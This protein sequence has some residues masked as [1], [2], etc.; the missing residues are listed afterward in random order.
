MNGKNKISVVIN[1]YNAEQHLDRVLTAVK[2]FDELLICDM[3]STDH[4]LEIAQRHG[5][6][7]VTFERK[8]YNIVE[9]AREYAIHEASCEWVLV[10]DADEVVTPA[11][12]D[13]LYS[14]IQQ[15][16]CPD[17][18][19]IPRKNYFMGRFLHSAYPDY[20]LRFFRR[21]LTHWPAVI[22]C[23][24]EVAGRTERISAKQ[25]ALA[26]EHLAND[27]V[28]DILQ[29]NNIYSDNEVPRRQHKN[30]G[31]MALLFRPLFRFFKS[32][33]LKRGFLDGMPG[34]IH[35]VLTA[36]YQFA[37]VAK[38]IEKKKNGPTHVSV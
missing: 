38:I 32:Y 30:Y 6:R 8:Q 33:I 19:F 4:T 14:R 10:V 31:L 11:L 37:I 18:L 3:E 9:P 23:S 13:Y 29:K 26:L 36:H 5:C 16:D 24:P 2:D 7:I 15:A 25:T 27:S 1:T 21:E 17:G 34:L 35:A 22:H 28:A 12:K 20:V